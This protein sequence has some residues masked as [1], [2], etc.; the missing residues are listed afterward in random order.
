MGAL[1]RKAAQVLDAQADKSAGPPAQPP[2][3]GA[4]FDQQDFSGAPE[5]WVQMLQEN[6]IEPRTSPETALD[7][8]GPPTGW[9]PVMDGP[10]DA[11]FPAP[12]PTA[13]PAAGGGPRRWPTKSPGGRLRL[14]H[15]G[16]APKINESHAPDDPSGPAKGAAPKVQPITGVDGHDQPA[17]YVGTGQQQRDGLPGTSRPAGPP[18]AGP[19]H[20]GTSPAAAEGV[21]GKPPP[22]TAGW[23]SA[24]PPAEELERKAAAR[25][26]ATASPPPAPGGVRS[27][28]ASRRDGAGPAPQ[29]PPDGRAAAGSAAGAPRQGGTARGRDFLD[30]RRRPPPGTSRPSQD[31]RQ[32]P[33]QVQGAVLPTAEKLLSASQPPWP[34]LNHPVP[35]PPAVPVPAIESAAIVERALARSQRLHTEQAGV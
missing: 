4:E 17:L 1:L 13:A 11:A 12:R 31:N 34:E 26:R 23:P 25:R 7:A 3:A 24:G 14:P 22:A 20:R 28:N 6:G 19:S 27:T 21:R 16:A 33:G 30:A 18:A 10:P 32:A 2:L 9:L 8:P 29:Q 35:A 15:H 5:H